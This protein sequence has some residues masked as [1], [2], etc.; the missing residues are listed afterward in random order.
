[1]GREGLDGQNLS[2]ENRGNALLPLYCKNFN[3]VEFGP[4]F[5]SI[6]TAEQL[7]RWVQQVAD[8]PGF[9]FCPK[10]PQHIT[11]IRRLANAEEQTAKFYESLD[12]FGNHL[13][14]LLLQLGENF[15]PKSF[16]QLKS[17][18]QSLPPSVKVSVEVRHKDWF[19]IDSNRHELF[20]LL[21]E[22]NIGTVISD[23]AGRRDCVHMEL[24]NNQA[25]IRFVGNDLAPSDYTRMDEWVERLNTWKTK[26]LKTVWFF[27]HQHNEQ[28][29]PEACAYLIKRLNEK[30]G[31][32]IAGP[33][34]LTE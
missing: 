34:F 30:L 10:F 28:F 3:T 8:A 24:T 32:S 18:L 19:G 13:G 11:H 5:Y 4:T 9:K 14:P 22:L 16:P 27:M 33:R 17:Y 31:T 25:V 7:N 29:V 26:G 2:P 6:Y 15:S 20:E 23:T 21:R 12:A 1:M